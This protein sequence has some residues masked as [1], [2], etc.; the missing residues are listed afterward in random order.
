MPNIAQKIYD[1]MSQK[2]DMA[3]N[4]DAFAK[5]LA[6][7]EARRTVYDA[8]SQHYNM[9][10]WEDF[11]SE[12]S[13][14]YTIAAPENT[15]ISEAP[16]DATAATP[17]AG[18]STAPA[19]RLAM[20]PESGG[21]MTEQGKQ[22]TA[23]DGSPGDLWGQSLQ[24]L[25]RAG[26]GMFDYAQS[27]NR[28]SE[29]FGLDRTVTGKKYE[30]TIDYGE[31]AKALNE[32]IDA[33][34]VEQP[35][36]K[37]TRPPEKLAEYLTD[38]KRFA[39][40]ILTNAP[41]TAAL[42]LTT[43]VAPTTAIMAMN[44]IEGGQ[45]AQ[46]IREYEKQTGRKLDSAQAAL[47][48]FVVGAVNAALEQTG[49]E[50]I[51]EKS[52][53]SN[54]I[55]DAIKRV[56]FSGLVEGGTEGAQEANQLIAEVL[57]DQG[58]DPQWADRLVSNAVAG[59][60]SGGALT[61]GGTGATTIYEKASERR[62]A[63]MRMD[64]YIDSVQEDLR[65][66]VSK[67]IK[68]EETPA[69]TV[70]PEQ[71][72]TT[73]TEQEQILAQEQAALEN[74][75][76]PEASPENAPTASQEAQGAT[77]YTQPTSGIPQE[78]ELTET[79]RK[80]AAAQDEETRLQT[81]ARAAEEERLVAEQKELNR[82]VTEKATT[83]SVSERKM[84][85]KGFA[86]VQS[87]DNNRFYIFDS[88]NRQMPVHFSTLK[89]ARLFVDKSSS[90]QVEGKAS[91]KD[92]NKESN[93]V[94]DRG[95]LEHPNNLLSHNFLDGTILGS[96]NKP[97]TASD[98]FKPEIYK[99]LQ[100]FIPTNILE[101]P[102]G[103]LSPHTLRRIMGGRD[104]GG[105]YVSAEKSKKIYGD[106][107]P[108]G[109]IAINKLYWEAPSRI[110]TRDQNGKYKQG[111][112]AEAVLHE[113]RHAAQEMRIDL[114]NDLKNP[115][116]YKEIEQEADE[117]YSVV[118]SK[119]LDIMEDRPVNNVQFRTV[120]AETNQNAPRPGAN[121][122][123]LG[124]NVPEMGTEG[125]QFMVRDKWHGSPHV[126]KGGKFSAEKIG[127][128]EGAQ[129]FGWGLY[130]TDKEEIAKHYAG[131]KAKFTVG[132]QD[133]SDWDIP[134]RELEVVTRLLQANTP[135]RAQAHLSGWIESMTAYERSHGL[136]LTKRQQKFVAAG[137]DLML[138][139]GKPDAI[140]QSRN[141]YRVSIGKEG[142]VENWMD[143]DKVPTAEQIKQINEQAKKE[144]INYQFPENPSPDFFK[145]A[146]IY[147]TL[148][149]ALAETDKEE[150][151]GVGSS[152]GISDKDTSLFLNR[153]GIDGIR[154]PAGTL[155]G[156]EQKDVY[157]Y[158]VF[159]EN[160]IKVEEH[161]Q[162][163][164]NKG[165]KSIAGM[166]VLKAGRTLQDSPYKFNV[167]VRVLGSEEDVKGKI[168]DTARAERAKGN[169]V[170]GF[171]DP[172]T[173]EVVI[174]ADNIRNDKDLLKIVLP[175]EIAHY[176]VQGVLGE[177]NYKAYLDTLLKDGAISKEIKTLAKEY[178]WKD[179][180]A[181][182]E[183]FAMRAE[184][185][186]ISEF[187]SPAAWKRAIDHLWR[188]IQN[189]FR[190]KGNKIIFTRSD[191]EEMLK[192]SFD[193]AQNPEALISRNSGPV[194][195]IQ[196]ATDDTEVQNSIK[197]KTS[198]QYTPS[199]TKK[200]Y[201]LFR[202]RKDRPG[203]LF[204]LFIGANK[205]TPVGQWI[206]AEHIP[207]KGFAERPGWHSGSTPFAPHLMKKDGTMPTNRVWA[208]VE[209]PDDV[210]WQSVADASK[211]RDIR[212]R[213]PE[214]GNY[215]FARPA[216]QGGVWQISGAIK[217]NRVLSSEEVL[218][219]NKA[220]QP[221]FRSTMSE[222]LRQ[223]KDV[224]KAI[225]EL[226]PTRSGQPTT[227]LRQR[228]E[229]KAQEL[230]NKITSGQVQ[231]RMTKEGGE[232]VEFEK[233]PT[234]DAR[235]R[236]TIESLQKKLP[237]KDTDKFLR[238]RTSTLINK[239][240]SAI[241]RGHKLGTADYRDALF[242]TKRLIYH[243]AGKFLPKEGITRGQISP[244][245][246]QIAKATDIKD[247]A[248]AFNRIDKINRTV[249][250]KQLRQSIDDI[251]TQYQPKVKDAKISGKLVADVQRTING[252][253]SII[254]MKAEDVQDK[255]DDISSRL[256]KANESASS[257]GELMSEPTGADKEDIYLLSTFGNLDG[258][259]TDE[260]QNALDEL[261]NIIQTGRTLRAEKD[262]VRREV[263][264]QRVEH[265]VNILGGVKTQ[266]QLAA[267]GGPEKPGMLKE[268]I[269]SQLSFEY[270]LDELS[271]NEKN[272]VPLRGF[273][274]QTFVPQ[275][276]KSRNAENNGI[277]A[278]LKIIQGK[279]AE[280]WDTKRP[281]DLE[282][283]ATQNTIVEDTGVKIKQG[284]KGV[285][286]LLS[287]EQAYKKWQEWQDPSTHET[288]A[289][290]GYTQDTIDALEKWID[291]R[292]KRW[293]EWQLYEWYPSYYESVNKI[294]REIYDVDLPYNPLYTPLARVYEEGYVS[295]DQLLTD[296]RGWFASVRSK[297]L[298]TR[299]KN[300][301]AL[302]NVGGDQ[303]LIQH[304]IE[305]EHFKAWAK[306]IQELRGT[307]GDANV[308]AAIRQNFGTHIL[309]TVDGAL[310][311]MARGGIDPIHVTKALDK[312]RRNFTT[313]VL[314]INFTLF[315]KQLAAFP[316]YL[317]EIPATDFMAGM[318][319]FAKN[320]KAAM[321]VLFESDVMKARYEKGFDRDMM[322][323]M[324]RNE[325]QM[326]ANRVTWRDAIMLPTMYGDA[327]AVVMGGWSVYKYYYDKAIKDNKTKEEAN[328]IGLAEFD[329]ATLRTQQAGDVEDLPAIMRGSSWAR[330]FTMFQTAPN[331]Y[332]R[333]EYNALAN[334]ARGRGSKLTNAKRFA[335]S[336]FVL[337]MMFQFVAS[338]FRWD[339]ER[340]L[341]AAIIGS[342]NGL[343]VVGDW[344][345][346]GVETGVAAAKGG[347]AFI[348]NGAIS[349]PVFDNASDMIR[350][351]NRF[352]K[353]LGDDPSK[354]DW[355]EITKT[356]DML[357]DVVSRLKGI[358]YS[359]ASRMA[360]GV[361]KSAKGEMD[362]RQLIG[363]SEY[364]VTP[365]SASKKSKPPSQRTRSVGERRK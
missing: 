86:I 16:S 335:V 167:P 331:S 61:A 9:D 138:A 201:K 57:T 308:R 270:L 292:V 153:A 179:D 177:E 186:E 113:M 303:M 20:A 143:W 339:N 139:L 121:V 50:K 168:G 1:A 163:K 314:G 357:V 277:R 152:L 326:V 327:A 352:F 92:V 28:F 236:K 248:D 59:L 232:E 32:R 60:G 111:I 45:T 144:G 216:H 178:G 267:T 97:L 112:L 361:Y 356:I 48:P 251:L 160:A 5:R 286:L 118:K 294:F 304:L 344:L 319:D 116:R 79:E 309:Q 154:Y 318:I 233:Q 169:I 94:L 110:E 261:K 25:Y 262:E 257:N 157:N 279:V 33:M 51:L 131:Q 302:R 66:Q 333:L 99:I 311:D 228:L 312:L 93:L 100:T 40:L 108:N 244:L 107:Y 345:E 91:V 299:T 170:S 324:Q 307:F 325:S 239:T 56:L 280:I 340:Q 259:T 313:A 310:N 272:T 206:V 15:T 190:K 290:M 69:E 315:P 353:Q 245:L 158:V 156:V 229:A 250:T 263:N 122:P 330:L 123:N 364:A 10:K 243:Y 72:A 130:F 23:E 26:A 200:A 238:M 73:Q 328:K 227:A 256:G 176:G 39:A 214:G 27:L 297:H 211:T 300:T 64:K 65:K 341:R 82:T 269:E 151:G 235:L 213:V 343:L 332:F 354:L 7:P 75:F 137:N 316:A 337:P 320:P 241:E 98:V 284:D 132:G 195:D 17:E 217:I 125:V 329:A 19:S 6:N 181:A 362:I 140:K 136:P 183:W 224:Y 306:T 321:R 271:R 205:P 63:R 159:D 12:V 47:A 208:E 21:I 166:G 126:L 218:K 141:L 96:K 225:D 240:I 54:S 182:A 273:L 220:S 172:E 275:I 145:G 298:L 260:L 210:D 70:P 187:K 346:R 76:A 219:I 114:W 71:P 322:L 95:L 287:Q 359:A 223:L 49:I 46:T 289:K 101:L 247:V 355:K 127:T 342:L 149:N 37:Y 197:F 134:G 43:I 203:E 296:T 103:S 365:T 29:K 109:F 338:G 74:Q 215:R 133:L 2:Y 293:A 185:K 58:L 173:N 30:P 226:P 222:T 44:M 161:Q 171:Y 192:Q 194:D 349:N 363:F 119:L 11:D 209:I 68:P 129:A 88:N 358:P 237:E 246:T 265:A 117:A 360:Q 150:N 255:I 24:N 202:T 348:W 347:K 207:T 81:E 147:R 4:Y 83:G 85:Y 77:I 36:G 305:M 78:E 142:V 106:L 288:F 254:D 87:Q 38:P 196:R 18:T 14:M 80:F 276:R 212:N 301:R 42:A 104:V 128:G 84:D 253:K 189:V 350:F 295:E 41:T 198:P 34:D 35:T 148:T 180:Y 102:V 53:A 155:S 221:S 252:I 175:H 124:A 285:P 278:G 291:P 31:V 282:K 199:R 164:E 55:K 191:V 115:T 105:V 162:F 230:E 334:L 193:F 268:F 283:I 165:Q 22:E 231:F 351:I 89:N 62:Q 8:M 52:A 336:H 67:Q 90:P 135:K 3:E 184:G 323:A 317:T 258:K 234:L 204:P 274:N 146:S 249:T 242:E 13:K 264:R 281:Q 120:K 188:F 174:L 266:E